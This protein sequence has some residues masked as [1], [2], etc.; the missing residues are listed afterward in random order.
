MGSGSSKIIAAMREPRSGDADER[1][2]NYGKRPFEQ[3]PWIFFVVVE[4]SDGL[5]RAALDMTPSHL[6]S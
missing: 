3:C 4:M 1:E 5:S 6:F 2:E